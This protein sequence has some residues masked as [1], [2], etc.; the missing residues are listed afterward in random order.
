MKK[1]TKGKLALVLCLGVAGYAVYRFVGGMG[2]ADGDPNLVTDRVWL[3][4]EPEKPTDYVH[5]FFVA[6]RGVSLFSRAS[7]YDFRFELETYKREGNK[8]SLTFP[9]TGRKV[10]VTYTVKECSDLPPFDLCLDLSD[11]PWGGPKRYRGVREQEGESKLGA[12]ARVVRAQ[13]GE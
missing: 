6:R 11:N 10:D 8:L 2:K 13:A 12:S 4:K 3:E 9:Q 7:Q 1:S 5:G